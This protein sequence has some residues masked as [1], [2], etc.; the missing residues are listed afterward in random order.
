MKS[1]KEQAEALKTLLED[2]KAEDTVLL[3]VAD[4]T[5]IADYFI[6]CSGRSSTHVKALADEVEDSMKDLGL[7]LLRIEGYNDGRW[8]VMDFASILL[9]IFCPDERQYYNME[10]L[11]SDPA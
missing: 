9:H 5:I 7:E 1:I 8:I 11:W 4:R 6:I 10:R 2:K 3:H